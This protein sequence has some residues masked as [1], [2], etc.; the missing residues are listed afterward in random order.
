VSADTCPRCDAPRGEGAECPRCGVIYARAE[1]RAADAAAADPAAEEAR[2]PGRSVVQDWAAGQRLDAARIEVQL[3]RFAVPGMLLL[4]LVLVQSDIGRFFARTFFGM[5]LH[6]LGHATAAWL[7]GIPAIPGAWKTLIEDERSFL[8]ALA[9]LAG[10]GYAVWWTW[11]NEKRVGF[12]AA[13]AVLGI[14]LIATLLLPLHSAHTFISFAGDAGSLFYGVLLMT[15]FFVPPEHKFHRDWLRWG[16]LLIGAASFAD[17]FTEW[18]RSRSDYSLIG[19]GEIE[20]GTLSDPS[21]L[22]EDGWTVAAIVRRYLT[23]GVFSLAALVP[24]QILYLRRTQAALTEADP[25]TI[26]RGR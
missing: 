18:W 16:F 20:C 8:F 12:A 4:W 22:V 10:L 15:A 21:Q 11:T 13:V 25:S 6:E 24:L 7:C 19:F 14:D 2:P 5:W 17:T 9:V 26:P 1:A 23:V 3:A